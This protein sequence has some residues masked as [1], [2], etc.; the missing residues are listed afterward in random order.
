[1]PNS[2][3]SMKIN[4]GS[5][6]LSGSSN[7][8]I[9]NIIFILVALL[10][11][12]GMGFLIYKKLIEP[13]QKKIPTTANMTDILKSQKDK[14]KEDYAMIDKKN[15]LVPLAAN[16]NFFV[17]YHM[18]FE[19]HAGYIGPHEGGIFSPA[20]AIPLSIANGVR[21]FILNIEDIDGKPM[22]FVR[23]LDGVKLSLNEMSAA[24]VI[25]AIF[26]NAFK[27]TIEGRSN[28]MRNDPCVIYL[29]FNKKPSLACAESLANTFTRYGNAGRL[30]TTTESGDF[31]HHKNEAGL[32]MLRPDALAGKIV[33]L[34]NMDTTEFKSSGGK[35]GLDFFINGIVWKYYE[36]TIDPTLSKERFIYEISYYSVD[37]MNEDRKTIIKREAL[38]KF[39]IVSNPYDI[40]TTPDDAIKVGLQ[41]LSGFTF[42]YM[43]D[44]KGGSIKPL[45]D[46][47]KDGGFP[48]KE[49][50]RY[51]EKEPVQI[52]KA[53]AEFNSN[54]G[55]VNISNM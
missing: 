22:T 19:N 37:Y 24:E 16:Q 10:I 20:D 30:L 50:V 54:G 23:K 6:S 47:F 52:S 51:T 7:N 43:K 2:S 42:Q 44:E 21:G 29:K 34:C 28:N 14:F 41:G 25:D 1:M 33:V 55:V 48:K 15:A 31:T 8:F 38:Q 3:N 35:R 26:E 45:R 49:D 36:T 46:V 13:S 32:L 39:F 11:L 53:P 5:G 17:N 12:G 4:S 18:M 40:R 27:E 9:G